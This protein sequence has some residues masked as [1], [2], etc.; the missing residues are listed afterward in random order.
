VALAYDQLHRLGRRGIW[1]PVVGVLAAAVLVFVVAP[2]AWQVV[3]AV[4]FAVSGQDVVDGLTSLLDLGEVTPAGLAYV[5]LTLA[6]AIPVVW[7]LTRWLHGLRIGWASSVF[8]R[9]RWGYLFACAGASVVALVAT[10]GVGLLLP[11]DGGAAEVSINEFTSTTRDFLLV[12]VLLTPLQAAAEE[13]LF[14]GYLLQAVGGV[15]NARVFAVLGSALLFALAHGLGQSWPIFVDRLA[16][17]LV[18]GTLVVLTGGLEAGIAMHVLNNVFAF[19][20][21]LAV[22]DMASTLNPTD[23]T[24]WSLPTTLTQSLVYLALAVWIARR[25]GVAAAVTAPVLEAP[26]RPV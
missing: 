14:R 3:F 19:G 16:F 12:I 21:A 2:L 9:L 8:R 23:G 17:G 11:L 18:A 1:R 15:V 4:W 13:Y 7:M 26:R 24:W 25:M 10:L 20:L 6:T 22:G 5:N